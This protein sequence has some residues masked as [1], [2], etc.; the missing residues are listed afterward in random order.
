MMNFRILHFTVLVISLMIFTSCLEKDNTELIEQHKRLAGELRDSKLY[1]GAIEEYQKILKFNSIDV[2]TRANINYL[3]G[4]IYFE[5]LKEYEQAASYYIRARSLDSEGSFYNEASKNL[6]ASLEKMGHLLDARRQ[7]NAMTDVD[8]TDRPEGDIE[9]ARIGN[10][11]VWLSEV[12]QQIQSLPPEVQNK[13]SNRQEKLKFIHQYIG[14]ELMFRAAE[15]ENYGSDPRIKKQQRQMYKQ[16]LVDKYIVDNVM[17]KIKIDTMDVRNF[18]LAHIDDKYNNSPYDSVKAQVFMD[19]QNEKAE[20]AFSDYINR[21]S[22]AEKVQ[23]LEH[24]IK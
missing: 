6:V 24:N 23:I 10:E 15:R 18:Y 1:E 5:N 14:V 22:Q 16:L 11:P 2:R 4:K 19:Y 13:F 21:L 9:I 8:A 7:L 3:I 17:P 20:T 12:E